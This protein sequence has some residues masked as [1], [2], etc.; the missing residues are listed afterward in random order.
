ME[1]NMTEI[2]TIPMPDT[3][4]NDRL[5]IA[6]ELSNTVWKIASG[7]GFKIRLKSVSARDLQ[8]FEQ[9]LQ[10]SKK[11][12]GM[13]ED[14]PVYCCYE[15]G[16]DGF[17]IHRYLCSLGIGNLVV[18]SSSIE[19]NRKYRRAKTDRL[20][21]SK[22]L[23]ML[24]R[25]INGETKLWSVLRV[26]EKDHEDA[27]RLH[28]EIERLK[29]ERTAH[30]NRI[31]SL[32]VLHGIVMEKGIGKSFPE[33]VEKIKLW[34]GEPLPPRVKKEMIRE[35]GRYDLIRQQLLALEQEKKEVLK[36]ESKSAEKALTLQNLRGIGTVSSWELVYEFFGWRLFKNGKE[37]GAAAGLAPTPYDSGGS[38]REQGISKSG[39][40][41]VRALMIE[42]GWYWLKFQPG[43]K[44]SRWF[45][46]RYGQGSKRMRRIGIVALARKL[47]ISLWKYLEQGIIPEGAT[48]KAYYN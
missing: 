25:Y 40:R 7:N 13:G 17:W 38:S 10:K 6:L 42:V 18:D 21:A 20:D 45:M 12:F 33:N 5:Y 8:Q 47:L 43:S 28:R 36:G 35:Y 44:L 4:R 23:S 37:V 24:I 27:R 29:K 22:L 31:R 3:I 41:R 16:R 1:G 9:E 26:P 39:N 48:L 15:A 14:V 11:H 34:N 32:L 46:E 19:V 30:S 2:Q